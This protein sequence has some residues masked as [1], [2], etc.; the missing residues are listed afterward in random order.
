M[1][2]GIKESDWYGKLWATW[3]AALQAAGL[4]PNQK[5]AR[6]SDETLLEKFACLI[7]ELGRFPVFA[8][9]RMKARSTSSLS[10]C[11]RSQRL[12]MSFE[13]TIPSALKLTGTIGLQTSARTESGSNSRKPMCRHSDDEG[14]CR[15]GCGTQSKAV[16]RRTRRPGQQDVVVK[17]A[18]SPAMEPRRWAA[19][20]SFDSSSG[21]MLSSLHG[22][23]GSE[24]EDCGDG[25]AAA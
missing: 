23:H 15:R 21:C 19:E 14:S 17:G 5:Q 12:S 7:H 20:S 18:L 1:E 11:L 10:S 13:P 25:R 16:S 9:L 22:F 4:S 8:E 2:T 3:G 6:L 24:A